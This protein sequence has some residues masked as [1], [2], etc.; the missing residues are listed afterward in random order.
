MNIDKYII[1]LA[2]QALLASSMSSSYTTKKKNSVLQHISKNLD[3][4]TNKIIKSNNID[5]KNAQK[6]GLSD[7]MID[8]LILNK[9]NILAMRE[10]LEK[11]IIVVRIKKMMLLYLLPL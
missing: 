6:K 2:E 11:I 7:S 9:K 8:R 3:I 5:I 10:G 4:N 1:K